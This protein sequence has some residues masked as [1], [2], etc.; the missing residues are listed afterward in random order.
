[1]RKRI[2]IP[3][4]LAAVAALFFGMVAQGA[5]GDKV[6]GGGQTLVGTTGAGDT[7]ALTAH[8]VGPDIV[9]RGQVQYVDR[10]GGTGQGQIVY[11]GVVN[12]VDVES[13]MTAILAGDWTTRGR[14]KNA[15]T[16][17]I[18]VTDNGSPAEGEDQ[19]LIRENPVDPDCSDEDED[20]EQEPTA[21]SRGNMTIHRR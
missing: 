18:R 11:H 6:T 16:F 2:F 13:D 20:E 3:V 5:E 10:D 15:G 19:V 9:G 14:E 1:M 8:Q 4:A 7:I 12:C 17:E 21:L